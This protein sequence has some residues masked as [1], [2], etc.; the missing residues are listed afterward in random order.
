MGDPGTVLPLVV[1]VDL[2]LLPSSDQLP[3][4]LVGDRL[5][6][7]AL[8]YQLHRGSLKHGV[9]CC[10]HSQ[11]NCIQQ[12]IEWVLIWELQFIHLVQPNV[13]TNVCVDAL[14]DGVSLGIPGSR[15][16]GNQLVG[17]H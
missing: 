6:G 2:G 12:T 1:L 14:K 7:M 17:L 13:V 5:K 3:I 10:S 15:R 11:G 9:P 16:P 8:E 4:R